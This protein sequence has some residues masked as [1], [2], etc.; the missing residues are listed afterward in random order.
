VFSAIRGGDCPFPRQFQEEHQRGKLAFMASQH[1]ITLMGASLLACSQSR[2]DQQPPA[3]DPSNEIDVRTDDAEV[4]AA[5]QAARA[6]LPTFW[7]AFDHPG[8]G[9]KDFGLKVTMPRS[10]G[11]HIWVTSIEKSGST[12]YG[13]AANDNGVWRSVHLGELG[14]R[15]AVPPDQIDDWMFL[16]D[17]KIVGNYTLVV[18]LKRMPPEVAARLRPRISF[19][20]ESAGNA[21]GH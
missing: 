16:R 1:W 3:P 12:I 17:G 10:G 8:A 14:Q 4:N 21:P 6:T 11:N 18:L 5:M 13:R 20:S 9:E 19:W 15:V 7:A 2:N